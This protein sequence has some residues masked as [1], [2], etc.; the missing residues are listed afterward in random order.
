MVNVNHLFWCIL[1][2]FQ[3]WRRYHRCFKRFL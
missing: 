2:D 3:T 1:T